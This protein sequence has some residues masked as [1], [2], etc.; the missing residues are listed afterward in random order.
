MITWT[1]IIKTGI[2]AGLL[3]GI[4]GYLVYLYNKG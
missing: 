4:I 1:E 2:T 3:M